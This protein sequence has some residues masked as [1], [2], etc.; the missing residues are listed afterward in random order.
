[1]GTDGATRRD[2]LRGS[3]AAAASAL[4]ASAIP[5][6]HAQGT[7]EAIRIALVGC[8]GRGTG[9][10]GNALATQGGPVRL[11]AMADLF[12]RRLADSHAALRNAGGGTADASPDRRIGGFDAARVDVPP[13]RRFLGFDGYRKAMDCLRPGDVVILATPA[14]FRGVHFAYAIEKGLHVFMEKPLTVD[15]PTTRRMLALAEQSERKGLKVGVGL[16]CRHCEARKALHARIRDGQIG[17]LLTLR[18][19]RLQGPVGWASPKP[20]DMSEVLFQIRNYLGFFW[21]SGGLFHDYTSHLIDE[22]CWMKGAWPVRASGSGGR[23]QR[24]NSVDQNFDHYNVEY[25]FADGARLF[26]HARNVKGCDSEFASYAHGTKGSA[27]ISTFAHHP[28]RCRIYRGQ[29]VRKEDLAWE[30]PQPEPDPYQLEWQHLV[31]AIRRGQPHN[32]ARR[33]AESSL[34]QI[35][36]RRAVHLGR[37]VTWEEALNDSHEFA[38]GLDALTADSPAPVRAGP[39]GRYPL[40]QPGVHRDREFGTL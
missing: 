38:P 19:Y 6:V 12:E 15:G 22:C 11:V 1:M 17:D 16:M 40:P 20:D 37:T 7:D 32:E 36:G 28:G 13:D 33:G 24:G 2:V 31:D 3:G 9:A 18:T 14:A 25:V 34:A 27:V 8:G 10:A 39:D 35:L 29:E 26:V 30:A 23:L 5:L 21:A 4:A